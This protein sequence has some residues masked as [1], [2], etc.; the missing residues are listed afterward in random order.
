MFGRHVLAEQHHEH[1]QRLQSGQKSRVHALDNVQSAMSQEYT[2]YRRQPK[3]ATWRPD[4][5]RQ[6]M[7]N[8]NE[9]AHNQLLMRSTAVLNPHIEGHIDLAWKRMRRK[10]IGPTPMEASALCFDRKR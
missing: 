1:G 3:N 5:Y 9:R 10:D 7:L 8:K 4:G 2:E 6:Q